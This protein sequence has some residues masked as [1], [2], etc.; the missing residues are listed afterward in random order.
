MTLGAKSSENGLQSLGDGGENTRK[1]TEKAP[2]MRRGIGSEKIVCYR[3]RDSRKRAVKQPADGS[4]K[5]GNRRRDPTECDA[6]TALKR[7]FVAGGG[8]PENGWRKPRRPAADAPTETDSG[9]S[10]G[11]RQNDNGGAP[12]GS[13]GRLAFFSLF[14]PTFSPIPLDYGGFL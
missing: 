12:D 3:N 1:E 13:R 7:S 14:C 9:C 4:K 11:D 5:L 2:E 6:E 10:H 8:L